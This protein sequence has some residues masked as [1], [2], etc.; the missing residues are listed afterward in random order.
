MD[1]RARKVLIADDEPDI[2]EILKYNLLKE[3]YQVVTAKDG[4]EAIAAHV[5][6]PPLALRRERSRRLFPDRFAH[7]GA[8]IGS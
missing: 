3:G 8:W 7:G 6:A 2:L 5:L 1:I 4:D